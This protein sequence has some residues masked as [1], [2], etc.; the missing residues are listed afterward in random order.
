VVRTALVG[1]ASLTLTSAGRWRCRSPAPT[2]AVRS[3]DP[4]G[5]LVQA[6]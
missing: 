3:W 1:V 4:P 2:C 6:T 5:R